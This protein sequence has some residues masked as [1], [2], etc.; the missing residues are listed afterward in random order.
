MYVDADQWTVEREAVLYGEWYCVGRVDDLG[1]TAAKR[2]ATVDVAGESVLVTSDEDGTLHAAYNVCRH[3]GSQLR[4]P[5]DTIGQAARD[6]GSLRC[7]Y[8][9]WTY[10]LDGSLLKAP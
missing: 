7:P 3:R 5:A 9:S 4:A 8:H 6:A 10:A 1:L 2:V